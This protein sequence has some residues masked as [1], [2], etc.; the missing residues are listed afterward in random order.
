MNAIVK[1]L[2]GVL[3]VLAVV[4]CLATVGILGYSMI[5]PQDDEEPVQNMEEPRQD[6]AGENVADAGQQP[7]P[8]TVPEGQSGNASAPTPLVNAT[9]VKH[10]TTPA[11]Q[12]QDYEESNDTKATC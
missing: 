12:V 5:R 6:E 7:V 3:A 11:N 2:T 1:V 10:G 8:T 9:P 4:A